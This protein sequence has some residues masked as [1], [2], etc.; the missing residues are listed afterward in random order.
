GVMTIIYSMITD[1]EAGLSDNITMRTHLTLDYISGVLL[2]AS[3]WIFGFADIVYLPHL[4]L[5]VLELGAAFFTVTAAGRHSEV[6]HRRPHM[7]IGRSR[8][9]AHG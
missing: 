2:A 6:Q 7:H 3:P 1:Y 4:I 8:T 9:T 5:G